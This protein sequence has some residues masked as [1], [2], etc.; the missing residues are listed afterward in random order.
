MDY[1][2]NKKDYNLNKCSIMWIKWCRSEIISVKL[3]KRLITEIKRILGL[4]KIS[5]DVGVDVK[6]IL[7]ECK[8]D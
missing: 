7:N 1:N 8:W 6:R 3:I 2:W 4:K 5:R